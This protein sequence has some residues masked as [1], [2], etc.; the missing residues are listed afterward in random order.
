MSSGNVLIAHSSN[1]DLQYICKMQQH[2]LR[3]R[4]DFFRAQLRDIQY[5]S[6]LWLYP[7]SN[8]LLLNTIFLPWLDWISGTHPS[9]VWQDAAHSHLARKLN[10]PQDPTG[11]ILCQDRLEGWVLTP[12]HDEQNLQPSILNP[13]ISSLLNLYLKSVPYTLDHKLLPQIRFHI[14]VGHLKNCDL[15]QCD[16]GKNSEE[17]FLGISPNQNRFAED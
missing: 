11:A 6:A 7:S 17:P 8:L 2:T 15:K 16:S 10:C 12:W 14:F 9:L 1:T 13:N 4:S 5:I 3:G